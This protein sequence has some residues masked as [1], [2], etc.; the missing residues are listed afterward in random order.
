M[1]P[2]RTARGVIGH[3]PDQDIAVDIGQENVESAVAQDLR[4][5]QFDPDAGAVVG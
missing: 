2:R 5:A 1:P 4:S 3:V